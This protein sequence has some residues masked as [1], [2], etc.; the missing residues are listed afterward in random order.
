M[1]LKKF[2]IQY[3]ILIIG[4][5]IS[6]FLQAINMHINKER[7]ELVIDNLLKKYTEIIENYVNR[8]VEL[9][10]AF[11]GVIK[12]FDEDLTIDEFNA[13]A[14]DLYNTNPNV[15]SIQYVPNGIVKYSYPLKGNEEAIGHDLFKD[16]KRVKD[17][18]YSR[19]NDIILLSGPYNLKQ[20]GLGLILRNPYYKL[21]KSGNKIFGGFSVCVLSTEK[22]FKELPSKELSNL[23]YKYQISAINENGDKIILGGDENFISKLAHTKNLEIGDK[24]WLLAVY[25]EN[26]FNSYEN[27]IIIFFGFLFFTLIIYFSFLAFDRKKESKIKEYEDNVKQEILSHLSHEMKTPLSIILEISSEQLEEENLPK[28]QFDNY[29]S[30]LHYGKYLFNSINN[31]LNVEDIKEGKFII[32]KKNID[33]EE[34]CYEIQKIAKYESEKND[35]SFE[36]HFED[37]PDKIISVKTDNIHLSQAII[38]LID[39][40]IKFKKEE[41]ASLIFNVSY[42]FVNQYNINMKF[43][44]ID[45]GIGISKEFLPYLFDGFKREIS[46]PS[47]DLHGFGIGMYIA[48]SIINQLDGNINVK[49]KKNIG[50]TITINI[51]MEICKIKN[52]ED[53]SILKSKRALICEDNKINT[54]ILKKMLE[55]AEMIVDV[56]EDGSVCLNKFENNY[57]DIILMDIRMAVM[58]GYEATREIRKVD[59]IIPI[60]AVSANSLDSDVNKSFECGM[61]DH[62]AK[63]IDKNLLFHKM[64]IH[65]ENRKNYQ[66]ED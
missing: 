48:K 35:V 24:Q 32:D 16:P 39:N 40:S 38:Y 31:L 9:T 2:K 44:I 20:G 49:S 61:N 12:F 60:I 57:Y 62:V 11:E 58:D 50:T 65:L 22:L 29:S 43:E 1:K 8:Y 6:I 52:L 51:P 5:I 34:M 55:S 13:L 26:S 37:L 18:T 7:D 54:L 64:K 3:I 25:K 33:V 56:A 63:P 36:Y 66:H 19:D 23:G 59:R 47:S 10:S 17:V 53:Y 4:L 30:I 41:Y 27:S 45:N 15:L 42:S 28:N 46:D 21:D 14:S